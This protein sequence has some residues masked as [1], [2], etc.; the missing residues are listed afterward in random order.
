MVPIHP[1]EPAVSTDTYVSG[2]TRTGA[3]RHTGTGLAGRLNAEWTLL[4]A[5]PATAARVAGWALRHDALSGCA[6][7]DDVEQ[8]V[9]TG[10]APAVDAVL[11][12]L[13]R[14]AHAGDLLAGRTVLQLMLGKAIRIA[15]T[16]IGRD[17]RE[18]LEHLAITALWTTIAT[19]PTARR[20]AKVAA[21]LA[22]DTLHT[23]CADLAH[24]RTETPAEPDTLAAA[25]AGQ[26]PPESP[27]DL[28]LVVL[29]AW[30]VDR[31]AIT[32]AEASLIVDIYSPAP[33]SHGG[34]A[35]A[36]KHSLTWPAARKRASRAVRKITQAIRDDEPAAA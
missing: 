12:S 18:S 22:M 6:C 28:E 35:A 4:R 2:P 36:A 5:D 14:L 24:Q 11:L 27:A 20:R 21:N 1:K 16:Q 13:L 23:V 33:G 15:A 34:Q 19:Y 32:A 25:L 3:R 26:S 31:H 29:L 17:S 9:T 7:L 8:A 30:A 10:D